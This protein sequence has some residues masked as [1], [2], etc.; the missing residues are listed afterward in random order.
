LSITGECFKVEWY[1]CKKGKIG[2]MGKLCK[3]GMIGKRGKRSKIHS[4][5]APEE[6]YYR[7]NGIYRVVK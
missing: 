6:C 7:Y 1:L 3:L 5:F 4:C 2:K